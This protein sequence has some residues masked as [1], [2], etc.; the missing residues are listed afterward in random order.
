MVGVFNRYRSIPNS[1]HSL[2]LLIADDAAEAVNHGAAAI[3]VSNHGARQIDGEPS[4]IECLPEV[5]RAVAGRC[6]VYLDGGV[7][8]GTDVVKALCLG[9]RAVFIGRP[10]LWGLAFKG[11]EG[12]DQV[13]TILRSELDRAMGLLGCRTI[14]DLTPDLVVREERFSRL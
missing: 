8:C 9:A 14:S 2:S 4:T 12:V 6:E 13:L 10:V 1:T 11:K 5:V 7:R 3:L